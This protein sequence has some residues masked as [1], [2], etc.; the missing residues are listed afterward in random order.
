MKMTRVGDSNPIAALKV[1]GTLSQHWNEPAWNRVSK[2]VADPKKV[3]RYFKE[4][5]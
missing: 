1:T 2:I 5:I 4:Q 3:D